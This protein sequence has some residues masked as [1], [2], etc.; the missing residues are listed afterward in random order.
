MAK[1]FIMAIEVAQK[2][3][4]TLNLNAYTTVHKEFSFTSHYKV[5]NTVF[6]KRVDRML[7]ILVPILDR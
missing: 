6:V 2:C 3:C 1:S 7:E 4:I 5:T